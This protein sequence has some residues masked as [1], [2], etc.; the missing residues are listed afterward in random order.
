VVAGNGYEMC[1]DDSRICCCRCYRRHG[2]VWSHRRG[3]SRCWD[4]GTLLC[5]MVVLVAGH[6]SIFF[7]KRKKKKMS[8]QASR[9]GV[10]STCYCCC[11]RRFGWVMGMRHV[12][13]ELAACYGGALVVVGDG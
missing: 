10:S 9:R 8:Y 13:L 11:C 3:W 1:R 4:V 5:A 7:K 2:A 6:S 12:T